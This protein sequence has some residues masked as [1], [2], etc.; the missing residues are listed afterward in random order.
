MKWGLAFKGTPSLINEI[1][2]FSINFEIKFWPSKSS[3]IKKRQ[4]KEENH[5]LEYQDL[6]C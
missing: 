5:V 2:T 6:C 3:A 1:I 4:Q